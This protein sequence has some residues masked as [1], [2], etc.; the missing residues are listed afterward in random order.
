MKL[1]CVGVFLYCCSKLCSTSSCLG[2][3][4]K[5]RHAEIGYFGPTLPPCHKLSQISDPASPWS[6]SQID[7]PPPMQILL[8]LI[9]NRTKRFYKFRSNAEKCNDGAGVYLC[10][11]ASHIFI[12]F[13]SN[14]QCTTFY[15]AINYRANHKS[16]K[17]NPWK[18]R[19]CFITTLCTFPLSWESESARRKRN[20]RVR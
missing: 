7:C 2:A 16:K 15:H 13:H 10:N 5:V 1:N 12:I 6:M 4:H 14:V 8:S 11:F 20:T 19:E 9:K 3:V 18:L 17:V